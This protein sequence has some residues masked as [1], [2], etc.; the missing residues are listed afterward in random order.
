MEKNIVERH[1]IENLLGKKADNISKKELRKLTKAF[2]EGGKAAVLS[3]KGTP[4]QSAQALRKVH[5][6][7]EDA[8]RKLAID[9]DPGY[10]DVIKSPRWRSIEKVLES[11]KEELLSYPNVIGIAAGYKYSSEIS[12]EYKCITVFVNDKKSESSLNDS[13]E[14]KIPGRIEVDGFK[15]VLTDVIELKNLE[16]YVA[17][18]GKVR[19]KGGQGFG[20]LGV[21]GVDRATKKNIALTAMHVF[22]GIEKFPDSS[23]PNAPQAELSCNLTN[24]LLTGELMQGTRDGIDAAKVSFNQEHTPN[25]FIDGIGEVKYWR[26]IDLDADWNIPVQ[27]RGGATNAVAY[28][29][30]IN[31]GI[32]LR[33]HNLSSAIL[34]KIKALKGDSGAALLDNHNYLLG[35]L[36]GGDN[37]YQVFSP[38]SSVFHFLA[39]NLY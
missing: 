34:V 37:D 27:M 12:S 8:K 16:E 29:K 32:Y 5:E 10:K 26:P 39:C 24:Q 38:I 3:Q 31:P 18:G 22:S 19:K 23:F 4:T 14:K 35:L 13:Q 33:E 28:G 17:P 7:E 21:Y 15:P 1:I 36:W 11:V 6:I 30:I 2:L 25:R 9:T 20:T